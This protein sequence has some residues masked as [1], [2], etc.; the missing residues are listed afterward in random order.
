MNKLT[1][2]QEHW[3]HHIQTVHQS[4]LSYAEY[5]KQHQLSASA[6]YNAKTKLLKL[7]LLISEETPLRDSTPF[8]QAQVRSSKIS[9]PPPSTDKVIICFPNG[10]EISA[11]AH[12]QLAEQLAQLVISK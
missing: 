11:P 9:E 7:G 4:D 2:I 1:K 6:L 12:P 3:L 5:C 8:V 10:V